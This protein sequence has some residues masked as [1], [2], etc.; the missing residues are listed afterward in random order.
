[1]DEEVFKQ[2]SATSYAIDYLHPKSHIKVFLPSIP[3]IYIS[4]NTNA[5]LIRSDDNEQGWVYDL[6]KS[7]ERLDEYTYIFEI[8]K[9]LKFQDGTPFT[10]DSVM[11]NLNHFKQNPFL[12][13]NI[14]KIDFDIS[15]IGPYRVKIK[16][17]QKYEMFFLDLARVFFF[18]DAYLKKHDPKGE[19]TETGTK[20]PGAFGMG[21]YIL[22][23][24]YAIG[25]KQTNKIVLEANPYYWNKRYPKI[26]KVTVYTQLNTQEAF[27][28]VVNYEGK[29]DISPIPFNKKIEAVMSKYA[30]LVIKQSTNNIIIFFNLMNGHKKLQDQKVRMALNKALNQENL[31]NFVYKKEGTLSPFAT[32][33][34]FGV[35]GKI[36]KKKAYKEQNMSEAQKHALLN[37]LVLDVFTQDRFMFLWQGIEYQLEQ[38]GVTLNYE[39][40]TSEKD[41]YGQLLNTRASKNTKSWDMLAWGDDDW[42]YQNPW[43]TLFIYENDSPWSIIPNDMLMKTYIEQFFETKI[44]E[45]EYENVVEKILYRARDM[46]YTLRVP[47]INKVI[48]VNKEVIFEPF[49]GGIIPLWKTQITN[50]HWSVRKEKNYPKKLQQ[51]IVPLRVK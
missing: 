3:Y 5:G 40:T 20:E 50:R 21:P 2:D 7:H 13:T 31:L 41:I 38:Y 24:G 12:F 44:G 27:D 26:Q 25:K 23:S 29:L 34:H 37:G 35:V 36:A 10:I 46:A 49:A 51:P 19:E 11:N 18:T 1:M 30:K 8:K 39:I 32:S 43:T 42:Y 22:K 16:L 9:N 48:A 28:N 4:K 47:S 17:K 6:A 33:V 45:V 14:D 15:K